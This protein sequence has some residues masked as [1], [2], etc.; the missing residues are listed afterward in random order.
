MHTNPIAWGYFQG[1]RSP[2]ITLLV[3][4]I[5]K[6]ALTYFIIRKGLK[7]KRM[8]KNDNE[9]LKEKKNEKER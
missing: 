9:K 3:Q 2:A 8:K 1:K 7:E 6:K 4:G 5:N